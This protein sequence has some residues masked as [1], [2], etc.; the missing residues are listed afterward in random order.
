MTV[1]VATLVFEF[2]SDSAI[3]AEKA[4]DRLIQK[5]EVLDAQQKRR[6]LATDTATSAQ[7]SA[8]ASVDRAAQANMALAGSEGAV[9]KATRSATQ[10]LSQQGTTWRQF[11]ADRM[12]DYMRMEGGHAG[13][14][15]RMGAEWKAYKATA[16]NAAQG[17]ATAMTAAEQQTAQA[18]NAARAASAEAKAAR[19]LEAAAMR[20]LVAATKAYERD[21]A[22]TKAAVDALRLSVDP[23]RAAQER[24]NVE[25][26]E[27]QRLYGM[28]AISADEYANA[29]TVLN[30]RL[31]TIDTIHRKAGAGA[32]LQAY[33]LANLGSQFAD[34]G[35]S[36]ASGQALWLVAIQ[37]GAQ[38]GG[39]F[40]AAAARGVGF[41]AALA[42][43]AQAAGSLLVRFAPIG[44]A[45]AV[46]TS[47]FGLFERE[48]DKSTK[49]ATTWGDTWNA[50]VK[51]IGAAI[52]DGPI[53]EGLRWLGSFF[54]KVLDGIVD[55]AMSALDGLVGVF[56]A[57]YLAVTKNWKQLPAVL[58]NFVVAAVNAQIKAI[59]FLVNKVGEAVNK[60]AGRDLVKTIDLPEFAMVS[61]K[62]ADDFIADQR[63]ITAEF[64]KTRESI[65]SD[66]ARQADKEWEARQKA[67]K[68][69]KDHA[70]AAKEV[71]EPIKA[72]NVDMSTLVDLTKPIPATMLKIDESFR[73]TGETMKEIDAGWE[74]TARSMRE[75]TEELA[76]AFADVKFS[77][78]DLFASLKR[79]DIGGFLLNIQDT[80]SGI[81]TLLAQGP[82]GIASLGSMAANAIGGKTGRA[83]GGGLG[84]A[85]G[86]LGLGAFAGSAAGAAALGTAGLGALAPMLASFA[87]PIGL[88]AGALYAAAKLLNV[89]GKPSNAG[90][91]YDLITGQISGNKRTSETEEAAKSAG[92]AIKGIEDAL[93]AAGISLTDTVRGLVIGTRD[94]TQIYL[95]SGKTLYSAVGDSGAAVDTAM[96][97]LLDGATFASEAQRKV[98]MAALDAGKGFD[99][100]AE[101]LGRYAEA[102]KIS[103]NLADQILQL[104]DPKAFDLKS[105]RDEIEAQRKAYAD[106]A[107]QGFLTADQLATING[108]LG[109]LEGL[110]LDEV[111]K[112]YAEAVDEA[113]EP[114]QD[115]AKAAQLARD[116]GS[117][118]AQIMR[119]LGD[120]AGATALERAQTL[121]DLDPSLRGLQQ[122]LWNLTDAAEAAAK[123][124]KDAADAQKLLDVALTA[125]RQ[126][127]ETARSALSTAYEREAG[128]IRDRISEYEQLGRALRSFRDEL[129]YGSLA[130]LDPRA[131]Y[132][133][134]KAAFE[135]VTALDPNDPTRLRDL[136]SVSQAFLEAS[137]AYSPTQLAFDRDLN[138]VRRAVEDSALAAEREV[139]TGRAQLAALT[140]SV[141]LLLK[142]NTGVVS[143]AQA[144]NDL[145]SAM[146]STA[147]AEMAAKGGESKERVQ[148]ALNYW[149]AK[150]L[151]MFGRSDSR[152]SDRYIYWG[153]K[154]RTNVQAREQYMKEVNSLIQQMGLQVPDPNDGRIY[155]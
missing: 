42:G 26:R 83:L 152:R 118:E 30:R 100:V 60:L 129:D 74:R 61:Q 126:A 63:R 125:A 31:T 154:R 77:V 23:L 103:G 27:A 62:V 109:V 21:Q 98:A 94:Q 19:Q 4:L 58:G 51:V 153:L 112:K 148:R 120:D 110:R 65:A 141:E 2:K 137:R 96:R 105:V 111:L 132:E 117:L 150:G 88:A 50:T 16:T 149:Y 34:I 38:I 128:V 91:G 72:L 92:S 64:K 136:Q 12:S 49:H 35:V 115:L 107:T 139:D 101:A 133:A 25:L 6:R 46:A 22:K 108:Q 33:E 18:A 81:T 11:V 1:D 145:K 57:A 144:I 59:E 13:A 75:H 95:Q 54:G 135:R 130:S 32:K 114:V 93:K 5:G 102:Q 37:Q 55:V 7:K 8:T 143:V 9:E 70:K 69:A 52:M 76:R 14:M 56:G 106:L 17:A 84:I 78:K 71:L 45:I 119:A 140:S 10:A 82:A 131:R 122:I 85:A 123:S 28:G 24:V 39:V 67:K 99:G 113:V 104:T 20:E 89:G 3:T 127:E 121:A 147:V 53:G 116:R 44:T 87:G 86:G 151:D 48:I 73:A 124:A 142:L 66:I 97:A 90:A 138:A 79:G 40:G 155:F 36:L 15:K 80:L 43:V 47:A 29:V 134:T 41:R 146:V 68:G